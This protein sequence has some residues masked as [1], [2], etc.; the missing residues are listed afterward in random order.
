[1]NKFAAFFCLFLI[2]L[3]CY[4]DTSK[5][6]K[7]VEK[8]S[9]KDTPSNEKMTEENTDLKSSSLQLKKLE[10]VMTVSEPAE[11]EL[12]TE[13]EGDGEMIE[14]KT[15]EKVKDNTIFWCYDCCELREL[16][17]TGSAKDVSFQFN[18]KTIRKGV[19]FEGLYALR[20]KNFTGG[21]LK[22]VGN[23]GDILHEIRIKY[24]GCY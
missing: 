14:K 13:L 2:T 11:G 16:Q 4:N 3:S 20:A 9:I 5:P 1:M 23:N 8:P 21:T 15:I 7:S 22:I 6:K 18:N 10:Y 12:D 24:E 19:D 17:F